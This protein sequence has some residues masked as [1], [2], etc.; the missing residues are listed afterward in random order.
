M[1]TNITDNNSILLY[2]QIRNSKVH[3]GRVCLIL[4]VYK[5]VT[6]NQAILLFLEKTFRHLLN[7]LLCYFFCKDWKKRPIFE[8]FHLNKNSLFILPYSKRTFLVGTNRYSELQWIS[9]FQ[10]VLDSLEHV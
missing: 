1:H 5:I 3:M 10:N 7:M 4:Y 6:N 2:K 8:H 9:T